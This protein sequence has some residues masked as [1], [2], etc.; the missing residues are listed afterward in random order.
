[1]KPLVAFLHRPLTQHHGDGNAK[2]SSSSGA[3]ITYLKRSYNA[4]HLRCFLLAQSTATESGG[5]YTLSSLL[6]Y[7]AIASKS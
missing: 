7:P 4:A 3:F 6:G 5:A 2:G 1:M